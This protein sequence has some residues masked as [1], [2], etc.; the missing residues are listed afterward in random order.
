MSTHLSAELYS[1]SYPG[2]A[3]SSSIP[4]Q[5]HRSLLLE[6]LDDVEIQAYTGVR[7]LAR[8]LKIQA[9]GLI[10][11]DSSQFAVFR[12][13]TRSQFST[14]D[15]ARHQIGRYTRIMYSEGEQTMIIKLMPA[16]GHEAA[17][18]TFVERLIY[19]MATMGIPAG[20]I[21]GMGSTRFEGRST[22]KEADA[23]MKPIPSRRLA[24]DWPTLVFESGLSESLRR[25][26]TDAKWWLTNSSGQVNIVVLIDINLN[27]QKLHIERWGMMPPPAC[28]PS[29][30]AFVA[31]AGNFVPTKVAE[32]SIIRNIV[33][34]GSD[35]PLVL[36]F[37]DIFLRPPGPAEGDFVFST[38]DLQ[39]WSS[40]V[41]AGL[42]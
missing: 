17:Y 20:E 41:W 28:R 32:I 15:R 27:A 42:E 6:G 37:D 40:S 4:D 19:S 34:A 9:D 31:A 7:S 12:P 8:T 24:T 29:T 21:V 39:N 38:A 23:A 11:G 16:A 5:S 36:P 1:P 25:L 14:L 35:V 26:R 30:R 2:P 33:T 3:L 22:S 10:A 13:V 18:T